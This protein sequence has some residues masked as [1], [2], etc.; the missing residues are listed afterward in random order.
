MRSI[1][2]VL[3]P[4]AAALVVAALTLPAHASTARIQ[5]A[6]AER[7]EAADAGEAVGGFVHFAR[8][9]TYA[10]GAQAV[11]DGGLSIG[12][13]LPAGHLLFAFGPADAF[14]DVA[15]APEVTFLEHAGTEPLL[16]ETA[17][18]AT[19]SRTLYEQTGGLDLRVH[20]AEG[21]LL[22]GA[23]VGIAIVDSGIDASH[24]DLTWHEKTVR[25]FKTICTDPNLEDA[26]CLGGVV[27]EDVQDSDTTSGHGSHVAGISAGDGTASD[28]DGDAETTGDRM[29]RG[30]APGAKLYGFGAGEGLNIVV[31]SAA[32]AFQWIFDNADNPCA[33]D[34]AD[35]VACPPIRVVNNSWGGTGAHN[36]ELAISKL[37][38][39]L[40]GEGIT[41]VFAAGNSGGDGT[42]IATNPYANND[43]EGVVSVANY[44]DED[45]GDRN[46]ALDS[47]SSR[48]KSDQPETWP[49]VAAPG[50]LI[51]STCRPTKVA[52]A[53]AGVAS[54]AY[55]SNYTI[56]AGTSM[57]A[58]H[59][60]GVISLL[61]QARPGITPAEVEDA[62]E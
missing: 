44:F 46:A 28:S 52:C 8:T 62:L 15:A 59:T 53:A 10:D 38:D 9:A 45:T 61:Y 31:P 12:A 22:D 37:S 55:P 57:A 21:D 18:W 41:V 51:T 35:P 13:D 39:A 50:T 33:P 47:S 11:E 24:P 32:A 5:P 25:N 7:L 34:P 56:L 49:D 48:G 29:F 6:L 17:G 42:A 1:S 14:L 26:G 43:T 36:P 58:P 3:I 27:M 2:R 16:M 19:R 23:G 30:V 54:P 4:L 40:V 20:D 60:S